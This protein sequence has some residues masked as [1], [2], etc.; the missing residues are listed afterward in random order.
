MRQSQ[1]ILFGLFYNAKYIKANNMSEGFQRHML[2][3]DIQCRP[4][5]LT[6]VHQIKGLRATQYKVL[7]NEVLVWT[8]EVRSADYEDM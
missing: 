5:F 6:N 1:R 7:L 4:S 3:L 2:T 8:E